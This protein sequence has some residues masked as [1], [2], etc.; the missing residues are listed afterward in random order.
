MTRRALLTALS[1]A[2]LASPC[3]LNSQEQAAWFGTWRLDPERSTTRAEPSPYRRVTLRI[4]PAGDGL[5]V[6]YDLVGTRGGVTHMEWTGR[7]DGHDYAVQG[8]DYVLTNAYR[9]IDDRRYEIVVKVDGA[10]AATAVAEVS[11]DGRTLTVVTA[12]K[13]G[14]GQTLDTTAVYER[15]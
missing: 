5:R 7:F 9:R 6:I 4:E 14:A 10:T 2:V 13:T 3:V 8:V 15:Q 1:T 11:P 12:E